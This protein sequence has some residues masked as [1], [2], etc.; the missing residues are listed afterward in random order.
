MHIFF[1]NQGHIRSNPPQ[2]QTK[3]KRELVN[4]P[5]TTHLAEK[6]RINKNSHSI[7]LTLTIGITFFIFHR[8]SVKHI[9]KII[10]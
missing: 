9:E 6:L 7:K 10:Y 2:Q 4:T 5:L 8:I 3:N 1:F